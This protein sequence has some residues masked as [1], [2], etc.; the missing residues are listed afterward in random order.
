MRAGSHP[1]AAACGAP[2]WCAAASIKGPAGCQRFHVHPGEALGVDAVDAEVAI[3]SE[4]GVEAASV[5]QQ[6]AD[7]GAAQSDLSVSNEGTVL[8][9]FGEDPAA[10]GLEPVLG[11]RSQLAQVKRLETGESTGYGRRFVDEVSKGWGGKVYTDLMNG[12][13]AALRAY[14]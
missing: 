8:T 5:V 2:R 14:P 12:L 11:W 4:A 1:L 9:P 13:D 7:S 6:L 10:D 3:G